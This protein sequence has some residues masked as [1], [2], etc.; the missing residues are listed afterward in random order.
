MPARRPRRGM[1]KSRHSAAMSAAGFSCRRTISQHAAADRSTP[2]RSAR[3][4]T[5]LRRSSRP[6]S[7][8]SARAASASESVCL[9]T[10]KLS[11]IP[12][13]ATTVSRSGCC[14]EQPA[15]HERG[16][17]DRRGDHEHG[18]ERVRERGDVDRVD[19]APAAGRAP[20]GSGSGRSPPPTDCFAD[21]RQRRCE[22]GAAAGWRRSSRESRCRPSRRSSETGSRP[23]SRRRGP[24]SRPRSGPRARA[25]ASPIRGRGRART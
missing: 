22:L 17:G 3:R 6:I 2:A 15:E 10:A 16:R 5:S 1:S 18:A 11:P 13:P 23:R 7:C 9:G 25:P 4:S 8:D 14:G 20:P 12:L 19:R 24:G 21:G